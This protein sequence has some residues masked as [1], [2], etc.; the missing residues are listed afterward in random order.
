M[1]AEYAF[2]GAEDIDSIKI[3]GRTMELDIK[4]FHACE[5]KKIVITGSDV[6]MWSLVIMH[7]MN[8]LLTVMVSGVFFIKKIA[9][10]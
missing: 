7:F 3:A 4:A 9:R 10:T 5:A 8:A 2:Y 6:V 1:I